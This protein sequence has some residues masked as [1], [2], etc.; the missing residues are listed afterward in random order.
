VAFST[1]AVYPETYGMPLYLGLDTTAHGLFATLIRVD[2]TSRSVVFDRP[3]IHHDPLFALDRVFFDLAISAELPIEELRVIAVS[4]IDENRLSALMP[5][6][7]NRVE[8]DGSARLAASWRDR[9]SLPPATILASPPQLPVEAIGLGVVSDSMLGVILSDQD[10]IVASG[11]RL[12]FRNGAAARETLRVQ[13]G[14]DADGIE[15]AL[16]AEPGKEFALMLPWLEAEMTPP[17]AHAGLRRFGFDEHSPARNVRSLVEGQMMAM[18]NHAAAISSAPLTRIVATGH[19]ATSYALLQVMANV[20]GADVHRL[21]AT[22][23]ASLGAALH[24]FHADR[25]SEGEPMTW[26]SVVS[27][28]IHPNPAYRVSPNPRLVAMYAELRKDYALLERVHQH[29]RPIC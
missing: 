20:F 19:A 2:G 14:L 11:G 7:A 17:V 28:F 27:G 6:V 8:Y 4:S 16:A 13:Y 21:D 26:R 9:Y 24:A 10:T 29:R 1:A 25:L 22:Q 5:L 23:P 15:K 3:I 18:A 12:S